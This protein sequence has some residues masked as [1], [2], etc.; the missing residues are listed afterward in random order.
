M[1][2]RS[3]LKSLLGLALI[4]PLNACMSLSA[5][6]TK[7]SFTQ[8]HYEAAIASITDNKPTILSNNIELNCPEIAENGAVVPVEV[9]CHIPNTEAIVI[10]V[11]KNPNPLIANY[12]FGKNARPWVT[13][14]L[15]MAESSK[16][17]VL[18]KVGNQYYQ[19]DKLVQI[20]LGGCD[21]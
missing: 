18:A 11:E 12:I 20:T 8:T 10:L 21:S 19:T 16:V 15:K 5:R 3:F 1:Q 13:S 9:K 7:K 14:R 6:L 4:V 17:T 2:R